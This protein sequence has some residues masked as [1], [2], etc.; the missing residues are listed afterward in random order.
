MLTSVISSSPRALGLMLLA[1][2]TT[3]FLLGMLVGACLSSDDSLDSTQTSEEDE[4]EEDE[5]LDDVE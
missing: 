4:L 1:I 5:E 3:S 2:S